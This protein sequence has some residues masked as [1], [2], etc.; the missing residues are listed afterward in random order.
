MKKHL[1]EQVPTRRKNMK[2]KPQHSAMYGFAAAF[3]SGTD[4]SVTELF[5][6]VFV[7]LYHEVDYRD[8]VAAVG[9]QSA[10]TSPHIEAPHTHMTYFFCMSI[11]YGL[12]K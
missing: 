10:M 6:D 7:P 2:N 4:L 8:L 11:D 3:F 9:V 12:L 1:P 5:V